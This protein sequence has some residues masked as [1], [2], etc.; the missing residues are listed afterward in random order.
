MVA[1][2]A[3]LVLRNCRLRLL[4]MVALPPL[5]TMPAPLKLK[6]LV[7]GEGVGRC[8]G[9]EC[10][11][12]DRGV[13]RERHVVWLDVSKKAVPVGTV[14]GLQLAAV[15]KSP[16]PG[17][18]SQV[19]SC[20]RAETATDISAEASNTVAREDGRRRPSARADGNGR[21]RASRRNEPGAM[22]W[23]APCAIDASESLEP[24]CAIPPPLLPNGPADGCGPKFSGR[25]AADVDQSPVDGRGA[26]CPRL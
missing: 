4:V 11:A 12:A 24:P 3:V 7:V 8:P 21:S 17:L 13:G 16:E 25:G 6:D 9:V 26:D 1:L 23:P 10:P 14:A 2:P 18:A 15:L 20:A 19:A 22:S 5:M